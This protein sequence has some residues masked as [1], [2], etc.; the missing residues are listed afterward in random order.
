MSTSSKESFKSA[1][2]KATSNFEHVGEVEDIIH[3]FRSALDILRKVI[4]KRLRDREDELHQAGRHLKTSLNKGETMVDE[5]H[6][7]V[8]NYS[9]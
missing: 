6:R 9:Y 8:L 1:M 4:K 7:Y 2:S 5:V 3:A